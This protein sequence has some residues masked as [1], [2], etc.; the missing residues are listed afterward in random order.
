MKKILVPTDLSETAELGLKLAVEIARRCHA[1][2]SLVHFTRHPLGQTF[3]STGEVNLQADEEENIFTLE[4][5]QA[6]KQKL[7]ELAATYLTEGL[8]IEFKVIDG[9]FKSG[10][11]AYMSEENVDLIVMGTSGEENAKEV[12]TGN[13]TDQVIKI[14]GCPVLSVRDGFTVD[15]FSNIVV[16]AAVLTDNQV[17]D[18]LKYLAD[19]GKCFDSHI[20]LVHVRDTAGDSNLILHEYFNKMA[21]IAELSKYSVTILEGD[22][23]ADVVSTY[24]QNVNAGLIAVL[25]SRKDGIFRI[26]SNRFSNRIIREEGRPVFT[27]NLHNAE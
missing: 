26:F 12:F 14:S 1:S 16:A 21:Q 19:I 8:S 20:H 11:D 3:S 7:E 23:A 2:I 4:Y 25:K 27:L 13:H 6:K 15:E 17:A 5:L 24:A 10:L 22:D 18:G 9:K